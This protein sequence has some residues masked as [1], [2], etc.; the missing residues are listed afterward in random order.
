MAPSSKAPL[1]KGYLPVRLRFPRDNQH[2]SKKSGHDETFFYVK[3]HH[4]SAS[5]NGSS[6]SSSATLFVANCPVHATVSTKLLL[7]SIFGRYGDV[8]RVTVIATPRRAS[9]S[10]HNKDGG[11]HGEEDAAEALEQWT[12]RFAAPSFLPPYVS[13]SSSSSS[14]P[15]S[16]Q[17]GSVE[18]GKFAH[19]V[20]RSTKEMKQTLQTLMDIMSSSGT[21]SEN[22]LL[23]AAVQ[24]DP[25]ELQ[26]LADETERQ[27]NE[28]TG[29]LDEESMDDGEKRAASSSS[30][31][32]AVAARYRA[33]CRR[34][35][36]RDAL[37]EECNTVMESFEDAEEQERHRQQTASI[38]DDDG[39]VTV[40]YGGSGN[41]KGALE[42]AATESSNDRGGRRKKTSRSRNKKKN[43]MGGADPAT[44]FYRFQTK[45]N[46]KRSLQDLRQRF[47]EDKAKVQKMKEERQYRP[48]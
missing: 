9:T 30:G 8:S 17:N 48:F 22:E 41:S 14:E 6:S 27:R 36:D 32:L 43:K 10:H 33:G 25:I 7:K 24:V 28:A 18:D 37:L 1:I 42:A 31:V 15:S 47:E 4:A 13:I 39:F 35:L 26:T 11:S 12:T 40:T 5:G 21:E 29:R 19:V 20:F 16:N 34:L 46:R 23:A 2:D 45:Q 38:P 44:D 3:E